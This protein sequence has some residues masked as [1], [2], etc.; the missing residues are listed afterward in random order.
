MGLNFRK[1]LNLLF[2]RVNF[3]KSRVGQSFAPLHGFVRHVRSSTGRRYWR[4]C[5]PGTGIY[6]ETR[7][8]IEGPS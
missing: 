2:F 6:Y 1:S 5:I 8:V 4:F 7:Q 3:S